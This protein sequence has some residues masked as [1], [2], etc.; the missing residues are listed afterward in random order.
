MG[1]FIY[2]FL[3]R[4]GYDHPLHP[5]LVHM[6][7]GLTVTAFF[8][9]AAAYLWRRPALAGCACHCSVLA[10]LFF[11]PTVFMG[12]L[13]WQRYYHGAWLTPIKLKLILAPVLLVLLLLSVFIGYRQGVQAK[14]M[15]FVYLLA[16]L[17]VTALGYFG[18]ELTFGGRSPAATPEFAAGRKLYEANCSG[19]HAHGGNMLAPN[20]PLRTAPQLR[21][22]DEFVGYLRDPRLPNGA[23]GSMPAFTPDQLSDQDATRLYGY[24]Q[25]YFANTQREGGN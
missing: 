13:D 10:T 25:H 1:D 16:L 12:V 20:L 14:A 24:V 19:C 11:F 5:V 23:K 8:L 18:G 6:P 2:D 21:N 3:Q 22:R 9:N 17:T 7:I 4:I 15:M